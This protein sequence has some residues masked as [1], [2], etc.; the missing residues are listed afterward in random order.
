MNTQQ[1]LE[2]LDPHRDADAWHIGTM[3]ARTA[4]DINPRLTTPMHPGTKQMVELMARITYRRIKHRRNLLVQSPK[5][6][7]LQ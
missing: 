1:A 5:A 6:M 3:T 2:I 4:G 7:V